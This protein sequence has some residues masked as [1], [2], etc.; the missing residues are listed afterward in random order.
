[1]PSHLLALVVAL[2]VP[3]IGGGVSGIAA[4]SGVRS[5]YRAIRRP[6]WTPPNWSFAPVWTFLYVLMGVASWLVWRSGADRSLIASAIGLYGAQL[7]L[8]FLWSIL[9]FGLRRPGWA[10][11]EIAALWVLILLTM[12]RF[13]VVSTVAGLLL[14]PYLLWV[15]YA[16]TLN[17]GVW[18]LNRASA[19]EAGKEHPAE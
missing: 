7:L 11:V 18:W 8:N 13:Q 12:L 6:P 3:I 1:M 2:A 17:A 10:L 9:F 4:V 19:T 5:W 15:T 16:V 14:V